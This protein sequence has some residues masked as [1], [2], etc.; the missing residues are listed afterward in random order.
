MNFD[1]DNKDNNNKNQKNKGN[2]IVAYVTIAMIII[3]GGMFFLVK[4]T[5]PLQYYQVIEYFQKDNVKEFELNLGSGQLTMI[6]KDKQE[7]VVYKVPYPALFIEDVNE[8]VKTHNKQSFGDIIKYDYKRGSQAP[9]W[10][11]AVF[12]T[13]LTIAFI[14]VFYIFVLKK[15]DAGGIGKIGNFGKAK[16]KKSEESKVTFGD[17]AGA[18]EEKEEL[19]EIIDFLKNP[20]KFN[21]LGAKIPK[22][23]L[24]MGP[25]GTGKTLIARAV[26]GEA[27]VPFFSISGSD[28]VEMFVGVGASRVRDVFN[29][30]KKQAPSIIFIDEIDAVGRRRGAGLG[31]GHD[32]REQT[33]NQL[34]VEMDGFV[35]NSGVIVIAA[36]NRKDVL[37]PALLRPGRFDRHVYVG[38]PDIKG[39]EEILKVHTKNKILAPD[40]DLHTIAKKTAGFVGADLAN[41]VNEAALLAAK[42]NKKSITAEDI[43]EA[44]IKV[45]V[46]PEKKS[47]VVT[48]KDKRLTAYHEAGHAVCTYHCQTQDPVHEISII[49]RG[50]AGGFTLSL[51]SHDKM[52][53]TKTE[54]FEDI[55]VLL[56]GRVAEKVVLDDI[57]SGASNDILRATSTARNMVTKYGFS[58]KLG[59]IVYG[60]DHDEV[61]LGRDFAQNRNYSEEVASQIDLEIKQIIDKAYNMTLDILKNNLEQLHKVAKYL[62][63][64]ESV[65]AKTFKN[66]MEDKDFYPVD[67]QVI[68]IKNKN[69]ED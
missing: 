20:Q 14:V 64:N 57:S 15:T 12:P 13:L 2:G 63:E 28:F 62:F 41:L 32:E 38:Y 37:D 55:V 27:D 53:H 3:L 16:V 8:I 6:L 39:R 47:S 4:N 34:L 5:K 17:V 10:I 66:L 56:G 48:E 46:G 30:A 24:L 60:N 1:K 52:Y 29:Q 11:I 40:V 33:L 44:T 68:K 58:D 54:M 42:K 22:G 7:P 50:M 25:P 18:D 45:I 59:P 65:D 31:G 9:E 43:E 26:A 67:T 21:A 23:V 49:P 36:T 19:R 35:E 69:Q 51:P 61:F